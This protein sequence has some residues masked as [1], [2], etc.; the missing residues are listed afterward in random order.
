MLNP[1]WNIGGQTLVV[2]NHDLGV[3][4]VRPMEV[5]NGL[6]GGGEGMMTISRMI[7][8]VSSEGRK[9]EREREKEGPIAREIE[10]EEG[11]SHGCGSLL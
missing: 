6:R 5:M 11:W 4:R 10:E 7:H 9:R 3:G 1:S 2:S 8:D